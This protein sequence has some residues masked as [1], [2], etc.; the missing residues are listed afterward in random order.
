MCGRREVEEAEDV[1]VGGKDEEDEDEDEVD[2]GET[3]FWG[4]L[5]GLPTSLSYIILPLNSSL[6]RQLSRAASWLVLWY[7][8][9][10]FFFFLL[11]FFS[12]LSRSSSQVSDP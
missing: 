7:L 2:D 6:S 11:L 4:A 5:L 8:G 10:F 12:L 3:K 1:V 9:I